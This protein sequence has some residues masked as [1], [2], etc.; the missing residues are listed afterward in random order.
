M[1]VLFSNN[2]RK[3][4]RPCGST[5]LYSLCSLPPSIY[6]LKVP[7]ATY[8]SSSEWSGQHHAVRWNNTTNKNSLLATKESVLIYLL[9]QGYEAQILEALGFG[10]PDL[11]VFPNR[12]FRPQV[13]ARHVSKETTSGAVSDNSTT[14]YGCCSQ[15]TCQVWV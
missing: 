12:P 6:V 15:T 14:K 9:A 10:F 1:T 8:E 11:V 13:P 7:K 4:K 5:L 3:A 2:Q